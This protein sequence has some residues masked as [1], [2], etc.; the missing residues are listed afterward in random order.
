MQKHNNTEQEDLKIFGDT[1]HHY[2]SSQTGRKMEQLDDEK[3]LKWLV[4]ELEQ[5]CTEEPD[6][7]AQYV[8]ALIKDDDMSRTD[9]KKHCVSE[10][11]DFLNQNTETFVDKMFAAI[12]DGS[13]KQ[14]PSYD[15]NNNKSLNDSIQ[16]DPPT[17]RRRDSTASAFDEDEEENENYRR[18]K[19]HE[20]SDES[21]KR[22]R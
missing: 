12:D 20:T 2:C 1:H 10:L 22:Q 16:D 18:R 21:N 11:N 4:R 7:L 3:L 13:Y 5:I 8:E 9:L 15:S 19:Y 14:A 6:V 17:N